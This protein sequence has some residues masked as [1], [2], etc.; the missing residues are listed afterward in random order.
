MKP[1]IFAAAIFLFQIVC[2]PSAWS[3][4]SCSSF[5]AR[6][7]P[8][9]PGAHPHHVHLNNQLAAI[10]S[11]LK[12]IT[13]EDTKILYHPQWRVKS[14]KSGNQFL[15]FSFATESSGPQKISSV[16]VTP[17]IQKGGEALLSISLLKD[18]DGASMDWNLMIPVLDYL[19]RF[20]RAADKENK[21]TGDR[22]EWFVKDREIRDLLFKRFDQSLNDIFHTGSRPVPVFTNED[23]YV[24]DQDLRWPEMSRG[25]F[26]EVMQRLADAGLHHQLLDTFLQSRMGEI[27]QDTQA[28]DIKVE[29]LYI[30]HPHPAAAESFAEEDLGEFQI[31]FRL[32]LRPRW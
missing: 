22:F 2:T 25:D 21:I 9:P 7:T 24:A 13:G 14:H 10:P 5:L 3:S 4:E 8:N 17:S 15:D 28:W 26:N 32:E 20:T 11:L 31:F 6:L 1:I 29:V 23:S 12:P 27:I 16:R 19:S 18:N 30:R